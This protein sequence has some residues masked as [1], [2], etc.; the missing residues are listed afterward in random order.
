MCLVTLQKKKD[1]NL[2][3]IKKFKKIF[4]GYKIGLSDHTNDILTSLASTALGVNLI[5]KHF[6]ISKKIR[7]PDKDFSIDCS[8][9]R[10]LRN[11]IKKIYLS[12]GAEKIGLKEIEKDSVKLRRSIFTK[13]KYKK[14]RFFLEEITYVI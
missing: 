14:R 1:I 11:G 12:L 2:N 13:K 7:S 9:L 5:E 3:T 4:K 8:Q 10:Q 6:I